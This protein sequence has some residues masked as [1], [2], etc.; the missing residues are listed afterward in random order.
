MKSNL[1]YPYINLNKTILWA[2]IFTSQKK[3]LNDIC[4]HFNGLPT[5]HLLI[6]IKYYVILIKCFDKIHFLSIRTVGF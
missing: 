3:Y 5:Y 2:V 6:L 4:F 1:S